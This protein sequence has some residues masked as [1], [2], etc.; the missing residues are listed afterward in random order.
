LRQEGMGL[1]IAGKITSRMTDCRAYFAASEILT[2]Y[3][4]H[5]VSLISTNKRKILALETAGINVR[6]HCWHQGKTVLL[7]SRIRRVVDQVQRGEA[8]RPIVGDPGKPTVLVLGDLNVDRA[9]VTREPTVAGTGYNC[10]FYLQK[11]LFMPIIFGKVGRDEYGRLIRHSIEENQLHSLLGIHSGKATGSVDIEATGQAS[12]PFHYVWDKTNNANDY[13]CENLWQAIQLIGPCEYSFVSSYLFVQKQFQTSAIH[14]FL[15]AVHDTRTK[16]ILDLV[17][18]SLAHDVLREFDLNS[19]SKAALKACLKD[20][21]IYCIV[22]D[23]NTFE[24][25]GFGSGKSRPDRVVFREL[26][27]NGPQSFL[28]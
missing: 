6:S 22:G 14:Q 16:L 21:Q 19:F 4:I 9:R 15:K 20:L 25:L 17:R 10:A 7:G 12:N 5:S 11:A 13:D 23:M 1:G 26:K 2:H 3:G 27:C 24:R 8:H 18:R 28:P